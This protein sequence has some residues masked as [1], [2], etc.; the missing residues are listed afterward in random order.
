MSSCGLSAP[1]VS[2]GCAR[3][4][5]PLLNV[6]ASNIAKISG[7]ATMLNTHIT[8]A[9]NNQCFQTTSYMPAPP[10]QHTSSST[11]ATTS[12]V[13]S[14]FSLVSRTLSTNVPMTNVS[15]NSTASSIQ[16]TTATVISNPSANTLHP[17]SA[18]SLF[19]P[20]KSMKTIKGKTEYLTI[21]ILISTDDQAD[22]LRREL[23]SRFLDRSGLTVT[24]TPSTATTY[25]RPEL[26]HHQHHHTHH[27]QNQQMFSSASPATI[28][29]AQ[30][31][32][33]QLFPP[34]LFKDISKLTAVD[35]QFYRNGMGM[36]T[37]YPGYSP[38][39]LLHSGVGGSTPFATP[40]HLTS[41]ASRVRNYTN[42]LC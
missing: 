20:S 29:T 10:A 31:T 34:P 30:V 38:T 24:P 13:V 25:V 2:S 28:A 4:T 37:G 33:G 8:Q 32:S 16:P 14:S 39:G 23:D 12:T 6:S 1:V 3:P 9:T 18:E 26:Q 19:Q 5:P 35:P 21:F 7:N 41:F 11:D 42:I 27:H 22:L 17:F 36:P 40:N 15:T